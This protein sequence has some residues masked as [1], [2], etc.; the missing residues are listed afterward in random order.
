MGE[1][2]PPLPPS[3]SLLRTNKPWP[4]RAKAHN[5][6]CTG[7]WYIPW[8]LAWIWIWWMTRF[9]RGKKNQKLSKAQGIILFKK[10]QWYKWFKYCQT[11]QIAHCKYFAGTLLIPLLLLSSWITLARLGFLL[12]TTWF[13]SFRGLAESG[14]SS[15]S[16]SSSVSSSPQGD[17]PHQN[18]GQSPCAQ[19]HAGSK[20]G[21][22][23]P[24]SEHIQS[25]EVIRFLQ[26]DETLTWDTSW[27]HCSHSAFGLSGEFP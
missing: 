12:A 6:V 1:N 11:E 2:P 14:K 3:P 26:K 16:S 24:W 5:N 23:E 25:T 18:D 15:R 4:N 21:L 8:P 7:D 17:L 20:S 10:S 9:D 13:L 19:S 22:F 27:T